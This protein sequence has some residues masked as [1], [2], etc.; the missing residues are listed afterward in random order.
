MT[1]KS[2]KQFLERKLRK[3]FSDFLVFEEG[4]DVS[5]QIEFEKMTLKFLNKAD[6]QKTAEESE[7]ILYDTESSI[8]DKKFALIE[9]SLTGDVK[10]YRVIE[11]FK[12][13]C[14]NELAKWAILAFQRSRANVEHVLSDNSKIYISSGLGGSGN[15]LRYFFVMSSNNKKNFTD[16]QK[17]LLKKEIEFALQNN[18]GITEKITFY[19]YFVSIICLVPIQI[20]L[21]SILKS[22]LNEVKNFGNFISDEVIATNT[23]IFSEEK[24]IKLI[25]HD[26]DIEEEIKLS[27]ENAAALDFFNLNED[28]SD[29][30]DE[31]FD[32]D[33]F[34]D[35]DFDDDDFEDDDD[36]FF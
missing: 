25:N 1:N 12:N 26:P 17:D 32:D 4:I 27:E 7:A 3:S 33:D 20:S 21:D 15:S 30:F 29:F 23:E 16:F 34:D 22:I 31:D 6:E 11:R 14:K 13:N 5:V 10:A 18:K 2:L 35:E 9:L 28:V 36:D 8:E 19:G 24:I